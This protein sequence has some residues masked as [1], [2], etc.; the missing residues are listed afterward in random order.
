M[1]LRL[2]QLHA[3]NIFTSD[4]LGL[5][6]SVLSG[7]SPWASLSTLLPQELLHKVQGWLRSFSSEVITGDNNRLKNWLWRMTARLLPSS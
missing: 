5:F 3:Q 4:N 7:S 2:G 1:I 6:F